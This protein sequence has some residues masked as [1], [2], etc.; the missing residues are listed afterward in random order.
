MKTVSKTVD[1]I[2]VRYLELK[3][4]EF[5][6]VSEGM[7]ILKFNF[8]VQQTYVSY[9]SEIDSAILSVAKSIRENKYGDKRVP[10]VLY[11]DT[12]WNRRELVNKSFYHLYDTEK[13][14]ML[15]FTILQ[16]SRL[17][18]AFRNKSSENN[19]FIGYMAKGTK[20]YPQLPCLISLDRKEDLDVNIA[21]FKSKDIEALC[22][23]PVKLF[24]DKNL[25][26]TAFGIQTM[27]KTE[28][29]FSSTQTNEVIPAKI[30]DDK[31]FDLAKEIEVITQTYYKQASSYQQFPLPPQP[32]SR[33]SL[34]DMIF[35]VIFKYAIRYNMDKAM[36]PKSKHILTGIPDHVY[37]LITTLDPVYGDL[38]LQFLNDCCIIK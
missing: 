6:K 2:N 10:V 4:R 38:V 35:D 28:G 27:R 25:L 9:Q 12:C 33:L 11:P 34:D 31:E 3:E 32:T 18:I 21:K 26:D 17:V 23:D 16:A 13:Y 22:F 8:L 14:E 1:M 5:F 24:N 7:D 36:P 37:R 20:I 19:L 15:V 30:D 29:L